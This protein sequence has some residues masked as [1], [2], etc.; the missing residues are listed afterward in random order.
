MLFRIV[1]VMPGLDDPANV[2]LIAGA[3]GFLTVSDRT[4]I[5][6]TFLAIRAVN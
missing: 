6:K 2:I 4:F 1:Y 5:N 3:G